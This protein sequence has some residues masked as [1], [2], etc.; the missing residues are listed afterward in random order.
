MSESILFTHARV[1]DGSG[2]EPFDGEVLISGKVIAAV[3][4]A[5]GLDALDRAA[6]RV[7]DCGGATLM[8]GLVESHAHLTWPTSVGRVFNT[9]RLPPEE[10]MLVTA[11]NARI[12]LDSGFTS[13]FSAGS[14]GL[15]FEIAL[16]EE[17]DGGWIP[18]PRLR[19]SCLERAPKSYATPESEGRRGADSLREY[20]TDMAAQGIDSIKFQLSSDDAF[21]P[22]GSQYVTY[23][24]EEV[25]AIGAAARTADVMLACHAQAADA[26][27]LAVRHGFRALYHC[28][29]ADEE[30]MDMLEENKD[31]VFVAPAVG[32]LWARAHEAEDFG[33]TR[34]VAQNMGV[35]AALERMQ[36]IM[37]ALKK[38][39]VRVLPGGDYGFPY[40]P[41]GTNARDLE[42]FVELFGYTPTEA[43]VA[44]TKL[45][46]ELMGQDEKIGMLKPGYLADVLVVAG[47]PTTDIRVLQHQDKLIMIMKDGKFHKSPGN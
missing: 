3:A 9:M 24:E 21:K 38:R 22:A 34:D 14:L 13:A 19:A 4:K 27:K 12:T 17:I 16:R 25:Q 2:R 5:G 29:L 15:R 1:F 30:A 42:H 18:G 23:S 26:I 35:Y 28:S 31:R 10:H 41:I 20:V 40:L 46:G 32:L 37:P 47:D 33:I 36:V 11:R 8:P 44:A 39:G 6:A 45:G 7:I 43:L